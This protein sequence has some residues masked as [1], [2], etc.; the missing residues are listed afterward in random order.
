MN[1]P[2]NE[3]MKN[4]II[5]TIVSTVI[6]FFWSGI[7][8]ML[9]W[10]ISTP[11]NVNVKTEL[12][13]EQSNVPNLVKLPTNTLTTE[14]FDE[15]F[16]NKISTYTTEETFSWI[17]TQPLQEDY[18][19][20]FIKEVLTQLIVALF[21]ALLLSLTIGLEMT[22]R[23]TIV[24]FAGIAGMVG[25][26]GQLMNWWGIPANYGVGVSANLIFGW[27]L[28]SFISARYIIKSQKTE[29]K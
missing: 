19:R 18:S 26:Y 25:A 7:S 14:K 1:R 16:N 13:A 12:T 23:L 20:Y 8:Q 2:K 27:L 5:S 28:V 3:Q 24:L 21:L 4:I 6:L 11:Q 15:Q 10:G 29:S 9:P 17:V 22:K